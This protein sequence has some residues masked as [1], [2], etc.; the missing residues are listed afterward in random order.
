M[1]FPIQKMPRAMPNYF[2]YFSGVP[3]MEAWGLAVTASGFARIPAHS[4]YPPARHPTDHHFVWARGRVL[5]ALQIV[6]ITGGRGVFESRLTGRIPA[7][8]GMAFALVPGVWH[9]YRPDPL[10]GWEESWLEVQ[11]PAVRRLMREGTITQ[12]GAVQT[13]ALHAGLDSALEAVHD[14]ARIV[15]TGFDPELTARA[16]GVLAVWARPTQSGGEQTRAWRKAVEAERYLTSHQNEA[17]NIAELSRKLGMAYS[18]FRR[19]FQKHTGYAPWQYVLRLRMARARRLLASSSDT[20]L[21][22]IA[23]KL[24]FNSAFHFSTAFKQSHG[25]SPDRW[26]REL[27]RGQ[28]RSHDAS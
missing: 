3:G 26:R 25:K 15:T 13:N 19:V 7:E 14:R 9:R 11:G 22:D 23:D 5:D 4:D 17:V 6:V 1:I 2:R 8:T 12:I 28:S 27:W 20:T 16:F 18:H 24:G 21:V 10:T